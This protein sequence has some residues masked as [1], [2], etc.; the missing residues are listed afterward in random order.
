[1]LFFKLWNYL[2]GYLVIRVEG[3]SLERFINLT[4]SK[5]IYMWDIDRH[6]YTALTA[7][8]N[9]SGFKNLKKIVRT[10]R[11]RVRILEKRGLPFILVRFKKRRMLVVGLSVFLIIIYGLSSFIWSIEIEGAVRISEEKL[12]QNLAKHGIR[13]GAYKRNLDTSSIANKVV[14]DMPE[15][16][17]VSIQLKGTKALVRVVETQ[18]PPPMIDRSIPCNIVAAKDGIIHEM[19]VLEGEPVVK[20]G[21]TVR[22][23]QLLVSGVI[24]DQETYD[25]R[26][27]H[28]MAEI[29]ARTWY[30]GTG[31]WGFDKPV[32]KRTGRKAVQKFLDLGK[33]VIEYHVDEIP[34]K[35][36]EVSEK[37]VPFID[38]RGL[39]PITMIVRE[40]YEVEEIQSDTKLQRVKEKA[41]DIAYQ[42]ARK[43]IPDHV[44]VV[45]KRVKYDIIEG[46]E[47]KATVYIEA[48]EDIAQKQKIIYN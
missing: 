30:E 9:I 32:T 20:V 46:K 39:I 1:M 12:L 41:S 21:D 47:V 45:D 33:W 25:V 10:S 2:L 11:C 35:K 48:I 4:V 7:C 26:Y 38:Q 44:K 19:L 6:S 8:I 22:K 34:F 24:E 3:L 43:I 23:G 18:N 15:L 14:I 28:A 29:N 31:T 36:Y 42:N 13:H 16:W 17:W 40:Y 37:R 27:V 5:G